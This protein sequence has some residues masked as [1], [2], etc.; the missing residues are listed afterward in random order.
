MRLACGV[1]TPF[2]STGAKGEWG[3]LV[4]SVGECRT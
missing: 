1:V 4:I 3:H 2:L